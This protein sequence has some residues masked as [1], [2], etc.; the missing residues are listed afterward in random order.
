[1]NMCGGALE[2]LVLPSLARPVRE[3][4]LASKI[5]RVSRVGFS[6]TTEPHL[7]ETKISVGCWHNMQPLVPNVNWGGPLFRNETRLE[8]GYNIIRGE[9]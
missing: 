7:D 5:M 2:R 6:T 8:G 4:Q 3:R 1:M 9:I